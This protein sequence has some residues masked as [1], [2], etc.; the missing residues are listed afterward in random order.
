[1]KSI[2]VSRVSTDEQMEAGNSIPAQT[3]RMK[4]YCERKG[5]DKPKVFEFD[6]SAYKTKRD[7]FDEVLEYINKQ[8]EVVAVCFDKVDRLS[9]NVF[10]KRVGLLYDK[11]LAGEIELHFVSDNQV[12]NSKISAVEKFQFAINLGLAKYYSDSVSDNVKRAFETKYANGEWCGKAP[13]G[14]LNTT[15]EHGNKDIE[16]DPKL[17]HFIVMIFQLYA[18]GNTSIRG[19]S[20][21]MAEEGFLS[22]TGKPLGNNMV[23]NILKNPFYYGQM[24]IKGK[25]YPHKYKPLITKELFDQCMAVR[26]GWKKKPFKHGSKS[27]IFKGL[28]TCGNCGCTVTAESKK[29]GRLTYYSCTDG[30]KVCKRVYVRQTELLKPIHEALEAIQLPDTVIDDL[31]EA[32]RQAGQNK[33]QF[34]TKS[35]E[36]LRTEYDLIE[37]RIMKMYDDK[38]D[39]SITEEMYDKKLREYKNRQAELHIKMQAHSDADEDFYLTA[40]MVLNLAKRAS[41]IFERSE[42]PEKRQFLNFLLQNAEL[43]DREFSFELKNPFNHLLE[44]NFR[45][46]EKQGINPAHPIWLRGWDSNPRPIG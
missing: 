31:T 8:K 35:L 17:A 39:G 34:H 16:P 25:L 24:R 1:M 36:A 28:I 42:V 3:L 11:A 27:F 32:L 44:F 45:Q 22:S 38:L 21:K 37:G 46:R 43:K 41:E 15:D 6:E 14:Y 5:L 4:Q 33:A 26:N 18:K 13:R 30:K 23:D 7:T 12:I 19:I 9:R 29:Q 10:D 20:R 40:N 2:I